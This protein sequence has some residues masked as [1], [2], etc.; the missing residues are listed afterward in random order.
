MVKKL[1]VLV[2]I[3]V[4]V[5]SSVSQSK[6]KRVRKEAPIPVCRLTE[7]PSLRGFFLGQTIEEISKLI[8]NFIYIYR[9]A[10]DEQSEFPLPTLS[11]YKTEIREFKEI[12]F[13]HITDDDLFVWDE[14]TDKRKLVGSTKTPEDFQDARFSLFFQNERL[15]SFI[16]YYDDY[17]PPSARYFANQLAEKTNLPKTGSKTIKTPYYQGNRTY[18]FDEVES[19]L[20]CIGFRVSVHTALRVRAHLTITDTNT[21]KEIL[22]LEKEIKLRKKKQE[23]ER[24]RQEGKKKLTLKP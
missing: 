15:F 19:A 16:I 1:F 4:F 20:K 6:R 14:L 7:A 13:V 10:K 2:S 18:I 11:D 23:Q 22:R 9:K 17:E 8:P 3:L 5:L 24:I 12:G 21:E